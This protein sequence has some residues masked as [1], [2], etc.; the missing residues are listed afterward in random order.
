MRLCTFAMVIAGT[1]LVGCSAVGFRPAN[2]V[3]GG[4]DVHAA[5]TPESLG[6][7]AN[8]VR[9]SSGVM[10]SLAIDQPKPLYPRFRCGA[11]VLGPVV[12]RAV[13]TPHGRIDK[14]TIV[15]GPEALREPTMDA[16]RQW[17]YKPYLL[18]G[19]AVWVQTAITRSVQFGECAP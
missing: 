1:L 12:M 9:V 11:N 14:L 15:T 8:P 5:V 10:A 19:M 17:T 4:P 13:V 2:Q 18:N 16:V 7:E 6:T 3:T